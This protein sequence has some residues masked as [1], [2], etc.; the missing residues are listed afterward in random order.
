LGYGDELLSAFAS[1][2]RVFLEHLQEFLGELQ[3]LR[4]YLQQLV[5]PLVYLLDMLDTVFQRALYLFTLAGVSI[6]ELQYVFQL[7]QR[8]TETLSPENELQAGPVSIVIEPLACRGVAM[9]QEE[10]FLL[11]VTDGTRVTPNSEASSEMVSFFAVSF[12][13]DFPAMAALLL[14]F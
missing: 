4:A 14:N 7:G 1:L 10:A 6:V 2:C 12:S 11:V 13:L 5:D 8:I 9:G 3:H